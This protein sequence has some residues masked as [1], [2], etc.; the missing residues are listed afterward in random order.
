MAGRVGNEKDEVTNM[1]YIHVSNF[2]DQNLKKKKKEEK[3][4]MSN[5]YV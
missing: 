1:F 2:Q 3:W 4:Q 5:T